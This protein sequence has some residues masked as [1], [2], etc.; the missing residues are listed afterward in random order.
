MSA[1]IY[2]TTATLLTTA[3]VCLPFNVL[4]AAAALWR[5]TAPWAVAVSVLLILL[6]LWLHVR[7]DFDRRILSAWQ[8][9]GGGAEDFDEDMQ[10]LGLGKPRSA[11]ALTRCRGA[12]RWWKRMLWA[13]LAQ[14]LWLLCVYGG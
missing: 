7:V 12:L 13:T 2:M 3:R 11:D 9:G 10:A 8:A 4:L 14:G 6:V 5:E 1:Q